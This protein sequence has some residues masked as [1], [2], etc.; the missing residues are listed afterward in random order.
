MH[1]LAVMDF[2]KANNAFSNLKTIAHDPV[3]LLG[4]PSFLPDNKAVLC[5]VND[6]LGSQAMNGGKDYGT[7]F[8]NR[9]DLAIVDIASSVVTPLDAL[10][11]KKNGQI[12]LPYGADDARRNFEPTLAPVAV[13]GYYW[14]V[15][16]SRRQYG[17]TINT[18]ETGQYGDTKRKKLWIAAID[19]NPVPGKDPSHPAVYMPGQ[20]EA[21]GN[22]R[23][24]WALDPCKQNGNMCDSGDECCNGFCRQVNIGG[25]IQKVCVPPPMG[26]AQEFEMCNTAADCCGANMGFSCINHHCAQP[27]PK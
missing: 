16:T 1:T 9:A 21:A 26:C 17:N 8:N 18:V 19:I 23:G 13:G 10:N 20:E 6:G 25:M 4:W 7:W 2:A 15:F 24:F 12:Y 3:N 27:P 14:V 22:M 11:G 5:D